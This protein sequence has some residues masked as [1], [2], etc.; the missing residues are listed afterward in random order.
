MFAPAA[1][2]MYER[3]GLTEE[4][5]REKVIVYSDGVSMEKAIKLREHCESIGFKP[6]F[7]IGTNYTNDFMRKSSGGTERS[8]ALNVVIK[9][10][11]VGGRPCVKISDEL[12]KNTGDVAEVKKVKELFGLPTS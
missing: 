7:G 8:H 10:A 11:Q 1:K 5:W 6:M 3:V 12:S 4:E 9:L 2:V